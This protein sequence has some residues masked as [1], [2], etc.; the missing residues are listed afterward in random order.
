MIS[1]A[2]TLNKRREVCSLRGEEE[3]YTH[4]SRWKIRFRVTRRVDEEQ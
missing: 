3:N 1:F 4:K 2:W